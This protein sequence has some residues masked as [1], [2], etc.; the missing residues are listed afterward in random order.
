M[1]PDYLYQPYQ[2][3]TGR[4]WVEHKRFYAYKTEMGFTERVG[5]ASIT[6]AQNWALSHLCLPAYYFKAGEIKCAHWVLKNNLSSSHQKKGLLCS[7]VDVYIIYV[8]LHI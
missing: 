8:Y 1:C 6:F 2:N 3:P 5:R 7:S 4:L